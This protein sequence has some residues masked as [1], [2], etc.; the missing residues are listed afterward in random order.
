MDGMFVLPPNPYVEAVT[1]IVMV[2]AWG[3]WTGDQVQMKT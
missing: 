3:P 1:P 2:F